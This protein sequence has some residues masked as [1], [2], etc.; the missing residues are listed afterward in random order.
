M[1][2][3][4]IGGGRVWGVGGD[5]R[6][7]V[8]VVWVGRRAEWVRRVEVVGLVGLAGLYGLGWAGVAEGGGWCG[9]SGYDCLCMC[10]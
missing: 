5:G 10:G 2:A 1:G 6:V 3:W 8:C 7:C 9:G 4:L